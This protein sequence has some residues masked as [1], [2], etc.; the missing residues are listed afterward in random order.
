[1]EVWHRGT[2]ENQRGEKVAGYQ[3]TGKP[4]KLTMAQIFR[5]LH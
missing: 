1:M 3:I 5:N 2:K 4:F